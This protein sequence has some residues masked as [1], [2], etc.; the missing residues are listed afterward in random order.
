ML[1]YKNDIINLSKYVS[2][3]NYLDIGSRGEINGWF[4]II[5][6]KL[7][8]IKFDHDENKILYDKQGIKKFYLTENPKQSSL[9][10]PKKNDITTELDKTRLNYRTI[11]VKVNTLDNEIL[12][13]KKQIDII[14]IDTQGSEYEILKGGMERIKKDMPFLFLETW[15]EEYYE[16][17][18][19]FEEIIFEMR[20]I[21]YEL[22][23]L[24]YASEKTVDLKHIFKKNIG[25][26]K[27][28]GL[29]LF[30]G[31]SLKYLMNEKDIERKIKMSFI[32]F[33]HN[34]ISFSYK[35]LENDNNEFKKQLKK[36]IEKRIKFKFFYDLMKIFNYI[37]RYKI[38]ENHKL[39]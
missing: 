21:G 29:N 3:L 5:K 16:E 36:N 34:L 26:S 22:Y 1:F 23:S 32:L 37:T 28:T 8:I 25:G 38:F 17:I 39:T 31:P 9:F 24:D 6:N 30:L 20:K 4:K 7:D 15:S 2:N 18:T 19:L 12:D 10:K 13:Y 14:K 11:D 27:L 33:I 35:I